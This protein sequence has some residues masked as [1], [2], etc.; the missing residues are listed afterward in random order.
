MCSARDAFGGGQS[1]HNPS[2]VLVVDS[3]MFCGM[4]C[5]DYQ[6]R[7]CARREAYKNTHTVLVAP[8]YN[9]IVQVQVC[10]GKVSWFP[11]A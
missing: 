6:T 10:C 7:G 5:R 9:R 3:R 8:S 4:P 11:V 1:G 2:D